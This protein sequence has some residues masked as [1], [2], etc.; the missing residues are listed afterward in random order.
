MK[1]KKVIQMMVVRGKFTNRFVLI[2]CSVFFIFQ[3]FSQNLGVGINIAGNPANSKALLDIDATGMNPKAGLLLPRMTTVERNAIT[4][5]IPE[6]LQIYNTDTHCFEAYYN[7]TWVSWACLGIACQVPDAPVAGTNTPSQTQIIWNWN[8][9]SGATGYKWNT[10]NTYGSATDIGI[11]TSKTETG[12]SS[13]TSY[14][15]YVWAYN[16]CGNSSA[17]TITSNTLP[18]KTVYT[19]A[20]SYSYIVPAGCTSLTVKAWG[21][22]GAT[23]GQANGGGGGYATRTFAV[24]AGNT[25]S[26]IV[27]GGGVQGTGG[28]NAAAGGAGGYGG[29][30]KGGDGWSSSTVNWTNAGGGGGRSEISYLS[31]VYLTAG[32][33]GGGGGNSRDGGGG[34]GSVGL[35]AT[36]NVGCLPDATGGTQLTGGTGGGTGTCCC[37]STGANG[38]ASNGG[39]GGNCTGDTGAPGG[40]GGGGYYGGGGGGGGLAGQW[41]AGGGGGSSYA[42]TGSTTTGTNL[43][44]AGNE[45]DS[46]WA[47]NAGRQNNDGRVV[48]LSY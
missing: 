42:P 5:T 36:N 27:G 45:A 28:I 4:S 21:G 10:S 20:G 25:V 11:S 8:T 15:R 40:G 37:G 9:V 1:I 43:G 35:T 3:S 6:S 26:I 24:T 2:I 33:G 46:D 38:T 48:L 31:T 19:T 34:G 13:N 23:G 12:L 17:T 29:G 16:T 22:G 14:T 18:P 44:I 41:G 30:G 7:G 47:A 32:G 39:K